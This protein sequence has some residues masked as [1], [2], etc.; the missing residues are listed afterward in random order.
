[1]CYNT[2]RDEDQL[3]LELHFEI[4]PKKKKNDLL[5][6]KVYI[7][8]FA[9]SLEPILR[10]EDRTAF[11]PSNWGFVPSHIKTEAEAKVFRTKYLTLNAKSETVFTLPTY[12]SSIMTRR[13]L[14]PVTGF[15]EHRHI[16]P[17]NKI[18]YYI[19]ATPC[20][21]FALAGIYNYWINEHGEDKSSY[22]ILTTEA[23]PLMARIHNS[24]KRMPL[25]LDKELE[26]VWIDPGLSEKDVKGMFK[27]FDEKKMHAH[28]IQRINS[29]TDFSKLLEEQKYV[30]ITD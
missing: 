6:R 2:S 8:G 29:K 12:K 15:F 23:N 14:I 11:F 1:M 22:S 18:P 30:E 10:Q 24:K 19:K 21:V 5:K 20:K 16:D 13:C 4:V 26:R 17:K 27:M 7:N 28:T 3:E 25:I 9:N